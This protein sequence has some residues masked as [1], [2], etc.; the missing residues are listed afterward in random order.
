MREP[1]KPIAAMILL[2]VVAAWASITIRPFVLVVLFFPSFFP[3]GLYLLGTPGILRWT[4]I[5]T[6]LYL[7]AAGLMLVARGYQATRN[8]HT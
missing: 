4:A 1:T 2:A 8:S 7:V 5:C 6:V 3:I